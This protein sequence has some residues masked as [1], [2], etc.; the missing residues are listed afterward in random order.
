MATPYLT[1]ILVY[2]NQRA[3]PFVDYSRFYIKAVLL[4]IE[5]NFLKNYISQLIRWRG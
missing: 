1:M 4:C 2:L 3:L 5:R